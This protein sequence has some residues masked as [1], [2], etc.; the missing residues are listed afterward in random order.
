MVVE[1]YIKFIGNILKQFVLYIESVFESKTK[2]ENGTN[3]SRN[4]SNFVKSY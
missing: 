1:K 4:E 2:S 3:S